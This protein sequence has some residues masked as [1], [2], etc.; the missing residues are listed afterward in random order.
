MNVIRRMF[1]VIAWSRCPTSRL[2]RRGDVRLRSRRP[3]PLA[4]PN[5]YYM[6]KPLII[7]YFYI[8]QRTVLDRGLFTHEGAG[9]I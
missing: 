1:R 3:S 5:L 8:A 9:N 6:N 7:M 4:S 2:Y